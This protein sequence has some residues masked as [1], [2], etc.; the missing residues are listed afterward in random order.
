MGVFPKSHTSH[1]FS[2]SSNTGKH[3]EVRVVTR[4]TDHS[5]KETRK[6]TYRGIKGGTIRTADQKNGTVTSLSYPFIKEIKPH[7]GLDILLKAVTLLFAS[8][9]PL[10]PD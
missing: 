7:W 8:L 9:S 3:N 6:P 10:N 4:T 2:L 1:Q 5:P